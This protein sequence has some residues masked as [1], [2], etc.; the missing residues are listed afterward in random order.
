M[1]RQAY[2]I[3][4]AGSINSLKLVNENLS[5]PKENEVI[6]EV[7]AIGLNFADLFAIQGLYSATPKESFIPGLE[8]SGTIIK[9]GNEV[10]NFQ[11]GDKIMGA[12]RFGA[13]TTH[14]NIDQRYILKLPEGWSFEEGASFIVQS[15]TAYYSLAELGNIK[16]S[17]TVLVHSAAGGV[18]IYANRIAKKFNA[19][20]IGTIGSESKRNFLINEGYDEVIV[21]KNNFG[22]QLK[23]ALGERKLNL[24]LESIGGKIFDESFNA[25][26]SS[27]RIIV[28]G[29]AQFMSK[30]S[31]PNYLNVLFK[32]LTRPKVDPLSLSNINK[33]VMGFNLIY[34][35]DRPDELNS[36]AIEILKMN[37][38]RPYIGKVFSFYNLIEALKYF[39][40][41]RS[42][43]K[44]VVKV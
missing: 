7:K 12:I 23:T 30:S 36:M 17:N 21:R 15:L 13:Y 44:V 25:L 34:L 9:K 6:V 37:L 10:N 2:R 8:Y 18:G 38:Q 22:E 28:Y 32:Y 26:A 29:G 39:Q 33:S 19:F 16:P 42:I 35:W 1:K 24:V 11:V 41:G 14:L 31:R 5:E 20:T 43:G 40:T 3:S 27:G 4:K